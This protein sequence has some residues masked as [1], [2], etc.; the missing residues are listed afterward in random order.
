[1]Q[2]TVSILSIK[3]EAKQAAGSAHFACFS[4]AHLII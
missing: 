3:E 4:I 2:F 1:M